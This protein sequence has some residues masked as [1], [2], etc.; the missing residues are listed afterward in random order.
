MNILLI[1]G[2][3]EQF[4]ILANSCNQTTISIVYSNKTTRNEL[5]NKLSQ[6]KNIKRVALA[7]HYSPN[8][9]F[10][11]NE[12]IFSANNT[13][14]FIDLIDNNNIENIDFLACN[15]L[16]D[17]NWK[18]FYDKIVKETNVVLGASNN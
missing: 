17:I 11:E 5:N 6:Y 8:Y 12:N 3:I 7:F 13:N 10:L 4:E 14:F 9:I 18:Q 1:D 2:S 16:Q 15:T